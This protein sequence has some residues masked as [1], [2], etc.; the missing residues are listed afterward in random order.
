MHRFG[1]LPAPV[2]AP[3]QNQGLP[4][5][6]THPLFCCCSTCL[7]CLT[8]PFHTSFFLSSSCLYI[9]SSYHDCALPTQLSKN[10]LQKCRHPS[11]LKQSQAFSCPVTHTNSHQMQICVLKGIV[12]SDYPLSDNAMFDLW[13][14][15]FTSSVSTDCY[16]YATPLL[17]EL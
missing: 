6:G 12:K 15:P 14:T 7:F 8:T 1:G 13:D 2:I 17:K 9:P 4:C 16:G 10:A 11:G 5:G 3:L